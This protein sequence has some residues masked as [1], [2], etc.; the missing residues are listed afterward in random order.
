MAEQDP[1][2][3][4]HEVAAVVQSLSRCRT[5]RVE[6][7][8]LLRDKP[9][10]EAVC[11]EIRT[12]RGDDE[13]GRTDGFTAGECD[14]TEGCGTKDRD[15]DPNERV[16]KSRHDSTPHSLLLKT[17]SLPSCDK[18]THRPTPLRGLSRLW[19]FCDGDCRGDRQSDSRV[20][21]CGSAF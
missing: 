21:N 1:L 4:R 20:G 19:R 15:A 9:R 17:T 6:L 10:V 12:H 18:K 8:D 3:R 2:V 16:Q 11:H 7:E 13:P 14:V 5:L